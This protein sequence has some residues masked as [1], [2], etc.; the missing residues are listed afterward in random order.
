V[1]ARDAGERLAGCDR[2][3]LARGL[4]AT[5]LRQVM[6]DGTFHA[7][8]H[9]GNVLVLRDG[10]LAL[11]DFGSVGRLDPLQQA[12]LRRL[13]LAVAR[14]NATELHDALLEL[15]AVRRPANDD[16]LE[17]TLAQFIAQHL[18]PGMVPDASMFNS[19]FRL[20]VSF[21][22]VFPPMIGGVFRAMVTLEGTLITLSPGFDIVTETGSLAGSWLGQML[23]P[24]SLREAATDEALGLLPVLRKLPRRLDR[25]AASL[26][27][28]SLTTSM[29]VL[30]NES[31]RQFV[32]A[33]VGRAVL[34]LLGATLGIMSVMLIGTRGGPTFFPGTSLFHV[35]GYVGLFFSTVLILRVVIAISREGI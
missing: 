11:I 1:N 28:G 24:T 29:R 8:P 17:R 2:L 4:L 23:S 5:M 14:R 35:L 10:A 22:L 19:L 3:E 25:I 26:E 9:P 27:H 12:A 6:I 33:L 32:G 31:D 21:G 16:V 7:D 18:G 20:L 30:A 15:A 13:L 34:A